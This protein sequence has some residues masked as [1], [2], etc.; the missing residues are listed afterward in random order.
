MA[1]AENALPPSKNGNLSADPPV[2]KK[3]LIRFDASVRLL[4]QKVWGHTVQSYAIEEF[5]P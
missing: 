5:S 4:L 3:G 2:S 1:S